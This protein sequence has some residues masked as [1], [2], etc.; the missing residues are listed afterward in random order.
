MSAFFWQ[1][2]CLFCKKSNF[3]QSNSVRAVLEIFSSVFRFCK[4]K[5]YYYW[6]RNLSQLCVRNP[7]FG[8]LEISQEPEKWQWR[9]D[10][11]TWCHRQIFFDV[12][13]IL[14]PSLVTGPSLMS[15]SS[16]VLELWQFS[17]LRD[18][19]EIRKPEILPSEF[20]PI[21][22]DWGK[23]WIPNLARMSLIECY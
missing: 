13:L 15:V 11:P 5:G 20:C 17:F 14:L 18:R 23:L 21:S 19:P 3:T 4:K 6:K 10:F 9:Y 2:F 12:V 7:A 16:I 1:K 22:G 8:L